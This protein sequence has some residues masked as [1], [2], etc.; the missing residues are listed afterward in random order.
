MIRRDASLGP[1]VSELRPPKW[2]S[3]PAPETSWNMTRIM[4]QTAPE[5]KHRDFAEPSDGC[6]HV[7]RMSRVLERPQKV[8][9]V[10]L[11][12]YL[13]RCARAVT[14]GTC[15]SWRMRA[16]L[17]RR[18]TSYVRWRRCALRRRPTQSFRSLLHICW[19]EFEC[20]AEQDRL[21]NECARDSRMRGRSVP[22]ALRGL[23]RKIEQENPPF[24]A[25]R[26]RAIVTSDR[27]APML[28]S[29]ACDG[30]SRLSKVHCPRWLTA[31]GLMR[32]LR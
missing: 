32:S 20:L 7:A 14:R 22:I 23:A 19:F 29:R 12:P 18:R 1:K 9:A 8:F 6:R 31:N 25:A 16:N 17:N 30:S 2:S 15:W 24:H 13:R 21:T 26:A 11:S 28:V 3:C 27:P 4:N 10:A 5:A